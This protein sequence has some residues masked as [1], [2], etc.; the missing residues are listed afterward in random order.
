MA[1]KKSKKAQIG[2][3]GVIYARFSSHNQRDVSIDQQV[4]AGMKKASEYDIQIAKVYAD[5]AISGKTD[6]RADFQRMMRDAEKGEFQF[7]VAWKSNRMGRNMLEA[8]INEAKLNA[9]GVRVV[10]VEEN[11]DDTAAGRFAARSMMNVNQFYSESMAED[12]IRGMNDNAENC[13]VNGKA[14]Y[15][16]KKSP[17]GKF[18][19]D[20]P[21]ARILL[22]VAE[23]VLAHESFVDIYNDLNAREIPSPSG[24]K[25]NRSSFH[26]MLTNERNRGVYIWGDT[27]VEGGMPRIMSDEMFYKLQEVL[28]TKKNAQGRHR[29]F[30]DYLLTGKL[31]CGHCKKPMTGYSGTS[32]SGK[33]H[34]YYVCQTKRL[35]HTCKKENVRRDD[36][37]LAVAQAIK[38][39]ALNSDV[40][41]WIADST[42]AYAKKLA[43]GEHIT[44]LQDRLDGTQKAIK[45]IMTAIEQGIFT[46]TTRERLL[47]LEREQAELSAKIKIEKDNIIT[48]SRK[49]IIAGLT[50]FRD[51][52]IHDKKYV[53]KLFDTFIVAVYLYDD[54][55]KI[56][57]SFTGKKNTIKLPF[58][59]ST[60][61]KSEKDISD[62][63]SFKL[64]DGSP[65]KS[66]TNTAKIFMINSVFVLA[67]PFK[68]A[69]K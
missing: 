37:E 57:F 69:D 8:M 53:A 48:V 27:R 31:F 39:Y 18:V 22:E 4:D 64:S 43:E 63:C 65:M 32:K 35:E 50:L 60:I 13:M 41:E 14:S 67:C 17:D 30:G 3:I 15:G 58:D 44:I 7:V 12:V 49:D 61:E 33:L 38:K 36:I 45:N 9:L 20:E 47:E 54:E 21:K 16:F 25:W 29:I 55:L 1:K 56:V 19:I 34:H 46:D 62:K 40:I 42:V 23:R 2:G 52:D 28:T 51:G 11:F 26:R 66:H 5:R 24:G 6:K 59:M 10:Y 68:K